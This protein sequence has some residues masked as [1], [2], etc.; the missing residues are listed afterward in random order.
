MSDYYDITTA[1]LR[2]RDRIAASGSVRSVSDY[3]DLIA[4][5]SAIEAEA[6]AAERAR[7]RRAVGGLPVDIKTF[8]GMEYDTGMVSRAAVLAIIERGEA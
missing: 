5:I 6:A 4:G 1:G 8:D 3:D 7:V 2:L